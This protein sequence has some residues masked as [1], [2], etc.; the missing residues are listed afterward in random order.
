MKLFLIME[1]FKVKDLKE[2]EFSKVEDIKYNKNGYN[3]YL[4]I[5]SKNI[6]IDRK[7]IDGSIIAICDF[8]V[9][10]ETGVIKMRLRNKNYIDLL[11]EGDDIIV[12]NC[13]VFYISQRI[14]I[15]VDAFGKVEIN[16]NEKGH[17]VKEV[18][19]DKNFSEQIVD[20]F[21]FSP[22]QFFNGEEKI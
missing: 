3:L 11:K 12:R 10:D 8:I 5:I 6:L 20:N 7:R 18:K 21:K 2:P 22:K 13:K 16:E 19:K 4:K 9:G 14:R 1:N 17:I 15:Q